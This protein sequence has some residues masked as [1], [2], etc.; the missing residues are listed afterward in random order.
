MNDAKITG[1][2]HPMKLGDKEF[3]SFPLSDRAFSELDEFVRAMF[4]RI[5]LKALEDSVVKINY[6]IPTLIKESSSVRWFRDTGRDF[7]DGIEGT[8]YLAWQMTRKGHN[9]SFDQFRDFVDFRRDVD[10][11]NT[12][13]ALQNVPDG[14][15]NSGITEGKDAGN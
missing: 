1:A 14:K 5:G 7:L 11:I 15:K 12:I 3:E 4:V 8:A 10:T 2:A 6:I 9:L 13:F